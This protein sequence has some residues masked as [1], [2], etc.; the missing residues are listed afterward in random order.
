MCVFCVCVG[1]RE[2]V[3]D[4]TGLDGRIGQS[5]LTVLSKWTGF[6]EDP[7]QRALRGTKFAAA[8]RAD[9]L[10]TFKYLEFCLEQVRLFVCACVCVLLMLAPGTDVVR[11]SRIA[12]LCGCFRT[13]A[14]PCV[15]T[16]SRLAHAAMLLFQTWF[17]ITYL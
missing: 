17:C 8:S 5:L 2:F 1:V 13:C 12:A 15:V 7:L 14:V 4:R 10:E 16:R 11:D 9:L 6:Y 3:R